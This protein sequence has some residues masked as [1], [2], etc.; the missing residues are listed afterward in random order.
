MDSHSCPQCGHQLLTQKEKFCPECGCNLSSMQNYDIVCPDC[1]TPIEKEDE[2]CPNCGCPSNLYIKTL[3]KNTAKESVL[4]CPDCGEIFQADSVPSV[5]PECG[6]PFSRFEEVHQQNEPIQESDKIANWIVAVIV[7]G[8]VTGSLYFTYFRTSRTIEESNG[9]L[10]SSSSK[11]MSDSDK[12]RMRRI[13]SHPWKCILEG[14]PYGTCLLEVLSFSEN[15]RGYCRI[16][17]YAGGNAVKSS[18]FDFSYYIDGDKV[19]C[20]GSWEYTFR[21]GKLYDRHR[22]K[23]YKRGSDLFY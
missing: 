10:S 14:D 3:K 12:E 5:C 6:C 2:P 11:N 4:S 13:S 16:I 20:E 8:L 1:G 19:Y 17:T 18:G 22:N 21:G 9:Y 7:I 15:G 23:R